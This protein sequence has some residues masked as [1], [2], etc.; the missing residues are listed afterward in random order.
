SR[1]SSSCGGTCGSSSSTTCSTGS[2]SSSATCGAGRGSS[3]TRSTATACSTFTCG[4]G[5]GGSGTCSTA[6]AC[7]LSGSSA[8]QLSFPQSMAFDSYGNIYVTDRNNSRV[9]Q[10]TLQTNNCSKLFVNNET[11]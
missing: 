5:C 11:L 10:F 9:Q 1:G 4:T 3:G 8:S 6:T 2:S 7:S